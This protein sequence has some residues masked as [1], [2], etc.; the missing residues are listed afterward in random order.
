MLQKLQEIKKT[1]DPFLLNF[2]SEEEKR[3]QNQELVNESFS[4]L[5]AFAISGKTVRGGLFLLAVRDFNQENYVK[6]ENDLL[7]IAAALELIHSGILIHDD[8][9]DQ[10]EKRRGQDSIWHQHELFGQAQNYKDPKNYGQSLAI[11]LGTLAEY[12]AN[13]ALEKITLLPEKVQKNIKQVI[14]QEIIKTY[15]AEMLDSKITLRNTLPTINEVSQMYLFKTARYTFSLPLQLAAIINNLSDSKIKIL[16]E[17]SEKL[18]LIFQIKDDQ[19]GLFATEKV[20]GKSFASDIRE[21]KKTIFYLTLLA[22]I[23]N[24]E[25]ILLQKTYGKKDINPEEIEKIQD[26]FRLH[27]LP[28]INEQ[29]SKLSQESKSLIEN[30][31][32]KKTANLLAEILEFNLNRNF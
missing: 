25:K 5:K 9:I 1:I 20:S 24:E 14:N 30:F 8:I 7:L 17:I 32:S 31:G 15:F 18:G 11:C 3:F 2:L 10:D 22:N 21:G 16:I 13:L 19:I 23:N 12:L 27:A 29:I 6:Y 26:L 4:K 28:Q